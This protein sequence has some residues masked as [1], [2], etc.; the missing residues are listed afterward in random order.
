MIISAV[1]ARSVNLRANSGETVVSFPKSRAA[2]V[3][4]QVKRRL[5]SGVYIFPKCRR[6][7]LVTTCLEATMVVVYHGCVRGITHYNVLQYQL[8]KSYTVSFAKIC[9]TYVEWI[10][11]LTDIGQ[12][13][14]ANVICLADSWHPTD[15]GSELRGGS[16]YVCCARTLADGNLKRIKVQQLKYE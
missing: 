9:L 14:D 2:Y 15:S 13:N 1:Y 7:V 10:R 5:P 11:V 3:T 12:I 8:R 6:P 4:D 16:G